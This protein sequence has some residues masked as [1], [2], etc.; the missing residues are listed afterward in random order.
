MTNVFFLLKSY[1]FLDFQIL[2]SVVYTMIWNLFDFPAGVVKFGKES[3]QNID[4]FDTEN[5]LALRLAKKV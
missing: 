2:A 5:D 1:D 3:G 4:T